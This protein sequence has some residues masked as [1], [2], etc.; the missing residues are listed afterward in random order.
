MTQIPARILL[1]ARRFAAGLIL[2]ILA[3][4]APAGAVPAFAV[5]TGQPCQMCHVGGFGPQLTPFGRNFKL[6]GYTQR[7]TP[8][9]IPLS[10]VAI[11]S[12]VA[13]AKDQPPP[14]T[15]GFATNDNAALDQASLIFAGGFGEHLGAFAQATYDGVARAFHWDNLDVRATTTATLAGQDAVLG[16]SLNNSPSVEDAWNT[17]P[18]WG[19]P[20]TTS[21]L[22]PT[23]ST[24]PLIN[25]ALAQTSLGLTGYAWVD[26]SVYLEAGAYGS[27]GA[28]S[29]RRLGVDPANP[30][31]ISGLAPYGRVA[32]Q[33]MFGASALEVGAFGLQAAIRP[34]LDRSTGLLDRYT[35]L[36]LDASYQAPLAHG[37][38]FAVNARYTHERQSLKA[39]CALALGG[40]PGGCARGELNDLRADV[41]YSW[42]GWLGG[43]LAAF[44]TSGTANPVLLAANR[45]GKPDSTGVLLQLDATPFGGRSQPARRANLRVGLQYVLYTRFDGAGIDFDGAGRRASDNNTLRLFTWLAF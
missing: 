45:T 44:D 19:F 3:G 40:P 30:G 39:S 33:K 8:F 25:G 23:P 12:Y 18:A 5:Q 4:A 35:D 34:G 41:S 38:L 2:A 36:G 13:T 32:W 26:S 29:L 15:H 10:A 11:A 14:P 37:D 7:T 20:Y 17:T 16:L 9:S 1:R 31:D 28:A 22:A 6:H 42:R 24:Q 43:T 27:P 21:T